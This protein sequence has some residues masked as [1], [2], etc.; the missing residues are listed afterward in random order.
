MTLLASLRDSL[1]ATEAG[2]NRNPEPANK[3][4]KWQEEEKGPS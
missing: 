3:K 2:R 4:V 1:R